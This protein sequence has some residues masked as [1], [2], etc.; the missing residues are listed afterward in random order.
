MDRETKEEVVA[1]QGPGAGVNHRHI[2][3][4]SIL[5]LHCPVG[6]VIAGPRRRKG[7]IRNLAIA[8]VEE[9]KEKL[10]LPCTISGK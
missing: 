10:K 1:E 2:S 3:G 6:L 8:N 7:Q 9:N 4:K 5:P